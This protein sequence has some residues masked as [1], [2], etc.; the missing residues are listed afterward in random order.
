MP[1]T[2]PAW[3]LAEVEEYFVV[4]LAVRPRTVLDI[5]ANMGA[6]ALRAHAEWP[7]ARIIC[8]EPMAGSVE[9]LRN[10]V[11]SGWAEVVPRAV[12]R[13]S[14][15]DQMYIGDHWVTCSFQRGARQLDQRITVDC[16][17][18]SELPAAEVVKIDTEGCELEILRGLDLSRTE[19][20]LLEHHSAADA[21]AIKDLLAE[22]FEVSF[23]QSGREV[24][25]MVLQR[26]R[27]R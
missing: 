4:S 22:R 13:C 7:E 19:V 21:Q 8:Y 2:L 12:R 24:G 20:L 10:I 1:V 26:R 23:E 11:D 25:T 18:A 14:G 15:P 27:D 5:G 16:I 3:L 9:V 6:F 17:A